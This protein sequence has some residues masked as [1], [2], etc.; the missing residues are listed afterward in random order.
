M[1]HII[2]AHDYPDALERRKAARE[3]HLAGIAALRAKGKVLYVAAIL[4]G[5]GDMAGSLLVLDFDTK[6]E[7]EAFIAAD[8]Y[9]AG[10][11]WD[12]AKID[13]RPCRPAPVPTT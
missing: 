12:P 3:A 5:A 6:A 2:Y 10:R 8:P 13:I 7:V 11:V 1:P 9:I 4:N